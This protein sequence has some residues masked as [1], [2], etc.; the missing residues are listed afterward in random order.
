MIQCMI[1]DDEPLAQ[2]VIENHIA[3]TAGLLLVAK[4]FTAAGAFSILHQQPIDLLFLD[5]K[6]PAIDGTDFIRS[7]KHPP[8][9]IFTTAYA[10]YALTGFDLQ[11][12]D[13]LLKPI[14]YHRFA[15]SIAR[16]LQ[17]KPGAVTP[18]KNYIY[19][20]VNGKLIKLFHHEILY[21]QSLKDYIKITTPNA[22]Y[23]TLLTMK[24][25]LELL[26]GNMFK[27]VHRSFVVNTECIDTIGRETL[28]IGNVT[29]RL[30]DN[31]KLN[32]QDLKTNR[33]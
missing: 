22:S 30:G 29:I 20:K 27:Q 19:I 32:L 8:A 24:S 18:D 11:A 3:Q 23:L 26:P 12:V 15:K 13:Y 4:C 16:Y 7:L 33:K 25:L 2:Q 28:T 21:A 6:M 9:F 31:Y 5:I 10:D 1:V 14:T 17:M